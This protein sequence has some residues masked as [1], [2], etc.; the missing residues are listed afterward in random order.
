MLICRILKSNLEFAEMAAI[1]FLWLLNH[2][3]YCALLH[4]SGLRAKG[5][6]YPDCFWLSGYFH[7]RLGFPLKVRLTNEC[8]AHQV[9]LTFPF[10][11]VVRHR[12]DLLNPSDRNLIDK[13]IR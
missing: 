11:L 1:H 9:P 3:Y 5:V 4:L 12:K 6:V 2:W 10:G 8:V 13:Q 7:F